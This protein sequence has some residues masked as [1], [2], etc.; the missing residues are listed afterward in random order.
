MRT[1]SK[2]DIALLTLVKAGLW[3]QDIADR[4]SLALSESEWHE[5]LDSARRQTVL[6]LV[7]RGIDHIVDAELEP[8]FE[9]ILPMAAEIEA[10][11]EIYDKM[12]QTI[13]ALCKEYE[14]RSL[15]PVLLKGHAVASLYNCPPMRTCGDIDLYFDRQ[16]FEKA[17]PEDAEKA[18]DGSYK[19]TRDGIIVEHHS[20]LLDIARPSMKKI[21]ERLID[22][23]GFEEMALAQTTS[24]MLTLLLL[25]SH[26]L[27]HCIGRG[28]GLRQFC[29]FAKAYH[30]L[31]FDKKEF[32]IACRSLG[33]WRW[34]KLL[35]SFCSNHLGLEVDFQ[36][37]EKTDKL[38][39]RVLKDGNF[40]Q[41]SGRKATLMGTVSS[42]ASQLGFS[43]RY[44]PLEAVATF[45]TLLIG[46][47]KS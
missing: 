39:A 12:G 42:F 24:P 31:E 33:I 6:G 28:I 32:E 2:L 26:I 43:L 17:A 23:Y 35:L 18:S 9:L 37:S 3:E 27:K 16:E 7:Y 4:T 14:E 15:H 45:G 19:Y 47:I 41:H 20:H 1:A 30:Q 44:A 8:P 25:D 22:R 13:K 10:Y 21:I 29:D 34:T 11:E 5:L 36:C 38:L 40:G 46:R